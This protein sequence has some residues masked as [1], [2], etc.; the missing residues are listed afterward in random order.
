MSVVEIITDQVDDA[1]RSAETRV[2]D[3][4]ACSRDDLARLRTLPASYY[5]VTAIARLNKSGDRVICSTLG[6]ETDGL[7][8]GTPDY[9]TEDTRRAHRLVTMPIT[10]VAYFVVSEGELAVFVHSGVALTILSTLHDVSLGAYLRGGGPI[11]F[12][13][14]VYDFTA[15]KA[16]E[17]SGHSANFR[18]NRLLGISNSRTDEF[19][20][21]VSFPAARVLTAID[22]SRAMLLPIGTVLG[23][24]LSIVFFFLFRRLT[25]MSAS[26]L[27]ALNTDRVYMEYQPIVELRTGR[28]IGAEA[29]VRWKR[30][31]RLIPPDRFIAAAEQAGIMPIVTRRIVDLV[32]W[33]SAEFLRVHPDFHVSINFSALDLRSERT[34]DMLAGLLSVSGLPARSFWVEMTETGFV[35]KGVS[36]TIE[37][38]RA[39]GIRVAVDD[40]GTGYANLGVLN[41]I[42]V[43]VLKI[44]K[45]FVDRIDA[46]DQGAGVITAIIS[47]ANSLGLELVAE[48]VE[49]QLQANFLLSSGVQFAQGWLF[50]R[51][52][53]LSA[54]AEPR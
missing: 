19:V 38:I 52:G 47:L 25:S 17:Q 13:R 49:T 36:N 26:L 2:D 11:I 22:E 50:G 29:L 12:S 51:P 18:D 20:A 44:D 28:C 9:L 31:G 6:P 40:F 54:L 30:R 39:M 42:K 1:I 34:V 14:G 10:G 43:D 23:L 46:A 45:R 24:A 37:Q 32:A 41:D 16:L 4:Q 35:E 8:L 48:G 33:D 53:P 5:Y 7:L 27:R 3:I 15:L 21:F